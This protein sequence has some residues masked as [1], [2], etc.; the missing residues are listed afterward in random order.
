MENKELFN[1]GISFREFLEEGK[2]EHREKTLNIFKNINFENSFIER[3]KSINKKVNVLMVAEIWCPDCMINVPIVGKMEELNNNINI[4]IV[5][6]ENNREFFSKYQ[7]EGSIK[8]PTFVFFDEDF[9]E[10]GHFIE[11]PS[12]VRE[13]YGKNNQ[14]EVILTMKKYR[15]SE[16]I[17][18]TL[19]EIL[20]IIGY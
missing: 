9:N 16:F 12:L 17:E 4:S 14:A 11:R 20:N 7:V 19:K 15:N 8:I 6:I 13:V 10:T 3:I 5:D 1:K 2:E 18:E